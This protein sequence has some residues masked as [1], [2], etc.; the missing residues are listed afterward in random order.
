MIAKELGF[1]VIEFNASDVRNK[2]S[3]EEHLMTLLGNTTMTQFYGQAA[4]RKQV[5]VHTA[6]CA[7]L[8]RIKAV[9]MD[10]V[11]GMAGNEDRGG[12]AELVL[13]GGAALPCGGGC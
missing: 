10:E 6:D 9:I 7:A 13:F 1:E 11:D 5:R 3:L 2:K 4:L 12:I 8:T